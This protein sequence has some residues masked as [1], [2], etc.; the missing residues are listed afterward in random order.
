MRSNFTNL[1]IEG[2]MKILGLNNDFDKSL[3]HILVLSCLMKGFAEIL[4]ENSKI[5]SCLVKDSHLYINYSPPSLSAMVSIFST[6]PPFGF[7]SSFR[8]IIL[9][10]CLN[11]DSILGNPPECC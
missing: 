8:Q 4:N 7:L 5:Y 10:S 6:A 2:Q 3:V 9:E 11:I 1:F